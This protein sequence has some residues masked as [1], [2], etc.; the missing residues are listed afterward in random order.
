MR[1]MTPSR[2][3]KLGSDIRGRIVKVIMDL[4]TGF[5]SASFA[6]LAGSSCA[7]QKG[8]INAYKLYT[9][10]PLA[11]SEKIVKIGRLRKIHKLHF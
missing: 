2:S 4:A 5:S 6:A 3:P 9:K 8:K 11:E 10:N 1:R 7:K